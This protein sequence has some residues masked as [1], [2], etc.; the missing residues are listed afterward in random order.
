MMQLEEKGIIHCDLRSQNVLVNWK[1][2]RY[3]S[4][5]NDFGLSRN[6]L[7]FKEITSNPKYPIKWTDVQVLNGI[8]LFIS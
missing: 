2:D 5:I 6:T 3:I 1:G 8:F 7:D 4:K